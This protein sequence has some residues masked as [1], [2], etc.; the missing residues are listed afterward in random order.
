MFTDLVIKNPTKYLLTTKLY[1]DFLENLFFFV[2][3]MGCN[4][5][6]PTPLDFT[7]RIRSYSLGK[8][9][10]EMF[11]LSENSSDDKTN[12]F[13]LDKL[14]TAQTEKI[15][16]LKLLTSM[17][18]LDGCALYDRGEFSEALCE[19]ITLERQ[20]PFKRFDKVTEEGIKYVGGFVA[21]H[22]RSKFPNLDE[23]NAAPTPC[24]EITT[25]VSLVSR[26]TF[27]NVVKISE[28]FFLNFHGNYF[29]LM[30]VNRCSEFPRQ[31]IHY[32]KKTRAYI[33]VK[34]LNE[35]LKE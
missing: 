21:H 15:S 6:H 22:F 32:F 12:T 26:E 25:W 2:I 4:N 20:V 8:H 1:Q 3:A 18:D 24:S 13:N 27:L 14:R 30:V 16:R 35:K 33:R 31:V 29:R 5:D 7:Y 28:Q 9:A 17:A 19:E 10:S 11:T 23:P 34:K